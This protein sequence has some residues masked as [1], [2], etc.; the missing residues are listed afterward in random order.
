MGTKKVRTVNLS[1]AAPNAVLRHQYGVYRRAQIG[2]ARS[3]KKSRTASAVTG[4]IARCFKVKRRAG[5]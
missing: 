5:I 3:R 2:V 4:Q 1:R